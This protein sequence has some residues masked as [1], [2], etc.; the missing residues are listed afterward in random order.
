MSSNWHS[1]CWHWSS[2]LKS[3]LELPLHPH[4][5]CDARVLWQFYDISQV[6]SEEERET[7]PN[8]HLNVFVTRYPTGHLACA[9]EM[10]VDTDTQ[11]RKQKCDTARPLELHFQ[12]FHLV[13]DPLKC[14]NWA[15]G[16]GGGWHRRLTGCQ[17]P[18]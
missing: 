12:N 17:R 9:K 1:W 18:C 4:L 5:G 10:N 14:C 13:S 3:L 15:W 6:G 2:P 7:Q 8:G 11:N 16:G